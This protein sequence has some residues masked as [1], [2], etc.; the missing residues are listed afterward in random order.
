MVGSVVK[1][2]HFMAGTGI[3][4]QLLASPTYAKWKDLNWGIYE[5]TLALLRR[6]ISHK[7]WG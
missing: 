6:T 4:V 7:N 1:T 3:L 2:I 5:H